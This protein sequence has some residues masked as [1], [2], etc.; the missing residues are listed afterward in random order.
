MNRTELITLLRAE[1]AFL[2]KQ[3]DFAVRHNSNPI[4]SSG[5]NARRD[6]KEIQRLK[7]AAAEVEG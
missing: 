3:N 1:A 6:E 7:V 2:H 4:Y 5:R